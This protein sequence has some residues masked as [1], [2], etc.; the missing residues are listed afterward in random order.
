[1][2]RER[3]DGRWLAREVAYLV[4]RQNG[5]GGVLSALCL[6]ALFLFEDEREI[7]FSAHEFKTAKKAYRELKA[8]IKGAPHLLAQV[9]RRGTRVVGFRQ[10]NEDTSITLQNGCVLR[11]MARSA[12]TGRGFP[13]QRLIVDEAQECS[14]ET[15]QA[16]LYI[17]SAQP[18]PQIVFTGTVPGPKNNGEVWES[19][20]DRGR[21]GGDTTLS[22]MEW[23]AEDGADPMAMDTALATNP[24]LPFRITVETIEG[25]RN[26]ASTPE[27]LEGFCRERLSMWSGRKGRTV[28][29]IDH[30]AGLA[31]SPDQPK[32][33]K[34]AL[35]I[36]VTPDRSRAT[37]G[38]AAHQPWGRLVEVI[39]NKAGTSWVVPLITEL[40]QDRPEAVVM[41]DATGGAG[42]LI[43]P[44][45]KAGLSVEDGELIIA[46]TR[47][48]TQAC[49]AFYDAVVDSTVRH[50][51]QP[52]LNLAIGAARWR[53]VGDARAWTRQGDTDISPLVVATL[54][55]AALDREPKKPK[56]R[57]GNYW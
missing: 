41:L 43:E 42:S 11:F 23:T 12:N 30:W 26:A 52:V 54:A 47:D 40:R 17:V 55:L 25:E 46:S 15:R 49:G 44:L 13:A 10:S 45:E 31:V 35:A 38:F 29:D 8:L 24:G 3:P 2:L 34:V 27:A 48:M 50:V 19:L 5:K 9:E 22:W 16:L 1:M 4:A 33:L 32:A 14:E 56:K 39:E 18:N 20:R 7:L 37:V 21:A 28:F 6:G 36:D 51:D 57:P 53:S